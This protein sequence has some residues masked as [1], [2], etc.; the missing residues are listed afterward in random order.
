MKADK[1]KKSI[2]LTLTSLL[3]ILL[4]FNVIMLSLYV[5]RFLPL[6]ITNE[7]VFV[8]QEV[9]SEMNGIID[10]LSDSPDIFEDCKN[11]KVKEDMAVQIKGIDGEIVYSY[12]SKQY[13]DDMSESTD[14]FFKDSSNFFVTNEING[15]MLFSIDVYSYI[16]SYNSLTYD[17]LLK[18]CIFEFSITAIVLICFSTYIKMAI[19]N[20]LYSLS[21]RIRS[22][23]MSPKEKDI[24]GVKNEIQKLNNDFDNLSEALNLEQEKQN[25]MIASMSH[26]IKTP[27]TS[28]MGYAEQLQKDGI[29]SERQKKYTKTIYSK[30]V[31]I[32]QMIDN[33]DDYISY[34]SID[35]SEKKDFT[36]ASIENLINSYYED[37]LLRLNV[38]FS[39]INNC[40][41]DVLNINEASI[42][43]VF[44]NLI[45]NSVK[46]KRDDIP[47]KILIEI[48]DMN[49]YVEFK[50]SD[51][52]VGVDKDE[53]SKIFEPF[54]T[55]DTSRSKAV[56]GLGLSICQEI[57]N[58]HNGNIWAM[59]SAMD[60]LC[61]CI[62]L[63]K[64]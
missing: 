41:N 56:S 26:D 52:G 63:K 28:I 29:S 9:T 27:L 60:G 11:V 15:R 8:K 53:L 5:W 46:H 59:K 34:N 64:S 31:S 37:D 44:G 21:K 58:E 20:P 54:Y 39:V 49:D 50:F 16:K 42:L 7:Y 45:D 35:K 62:L 32:K 18:I 25:R 2:R 17:F 10:Y 48:N 12:P 61:T 51:N 23:K 30:A 19:L 57:I 40:P 13:I 4:L 22:Y 38:D 36:V 6:R 33:L 24:L 3:L 14:Y 1:K 43:R 55:T 47:L